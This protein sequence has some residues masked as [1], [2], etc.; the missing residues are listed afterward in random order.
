MADLTFTERQ[1]LEQLFGMGSGYVLDFTNRTFADFVNDSSGRDI[2]SDRYDSAGNS[3]AN[4]LRVFW[5][6]EDNKVVGKLLNELLD[7]L[8]ET[9]SPAEICRLISARLLGDGASQPPLHQPN[10]GQI[11]VSKTLTG[12]K[13]EFNRLAAEK[14]RNK[15]GLALEGLL[16][17]AGGAFFWFRRQTL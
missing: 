16:N 11:E 4:R 9:S 12:L 14:D 10:P 1:K 7:Y 5:Q 3:K 15:A 17:P 6:K 13:E 2:Y 8:G